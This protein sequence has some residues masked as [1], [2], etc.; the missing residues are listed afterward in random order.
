MLVKGV[1]RGGCPAPREYAGVGLGL[2]LIVSEFLGSNFIVDG[3]RMRD[4]IG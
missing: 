3:F 4:C 2:D 1:E